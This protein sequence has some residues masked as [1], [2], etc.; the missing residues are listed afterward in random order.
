MGAALLRDAMTACERMSP[1]GFDR[2]F[3]AQDLLPT[4]ASGNGRFGSLID[5][6]LNSTCRERGATLFCDPATWTPY[7]DHFAHLAQVQPLGPSGV[8]ALVNELQPITVGRTTTLKATPFGTPRF[9][10]CFDASRRG[11]Q[12]DR[13]GR[14]RAAGRGWPAHPR[15]DH[16]ALR[17]SRR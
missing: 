16:G 4:K 3:P 17:Q 14:R 9:V 5:L 15:A 1:A 8:E 6:P 11:D 12:A 10:M 13:L 7:P 2:F